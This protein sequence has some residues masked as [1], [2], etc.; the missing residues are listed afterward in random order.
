MSSRF[1]VEKGRLLQFCITSFVF[2]MKKNTFPVTGM[3]CAACASSV[4]SI[5]NNTD[6]V[7]KA[8]VNFASNSVLVSYK[9]AEENLQKALEDIG[10][11]LIL[12][13]FHAEEKQEK[14]RKAHF[15][16]LQRRLLFSSI[17][18]LPIF[19]LGMFFMD[20]TPGKWI[21]MILSIP[22]LF[23]FGKSFFIGAYKQTLRGYANMDTLVA[24]STGVA[25]SF[26][27]FNTL[28]SAYWTSKG[29]I[30]HVYFEA[31]TV[32]ITFIT[33]GK[34][35][36]ERAKY[37]TGSAIKKLMG[38]QPKEVTRINRNNDEERV[39]ISEL[40]VGDL[41]SVKP[42][43]KIPVDGCLVSGH[44]YVDESSIS[45]EPIPVFKKEGDAVTSAG[46]NQNGAFVF[47]AEK[48]GSDT[49]LSRIIQAVKEAQGSKAPIQKTVDKIA[50]VFVPV[51]ITIAVLTF[52]LWYF[53]GNEDVFSHALINAISVLVIAC[54]CAL[55]LATPTALI[56][57][58]GRAAENQ[59]LIKDA[60]SLENAHAIDTVVLDKTGTITE[61]KPRVSQ[62][63]GFETH[64]D[65]LQAV[66]EIEKQSEHPIARAIVEHLEDLNLVP[67]QLNNFKNDPGFGVSADS[68]NG[69]IR[70]GNLAFLDKYKITIT[71]DLLDTVKQ[72]GEQS[73]THVY[74][75]KDNSCIGIFTIVDNIKPTSLE[76][77]N[78]LKKSGIEVAILSGDHPEV[79][80]SMAKRMGI[81][82]YHGGVLPSQKAE[83]VKQWVASGK[84]VAMVGD[85]VNDSEALACAD[86]S[87]AMGKGSDIAM[88]VAH[89]TLISSDLLAIPKAF[90]LS[91]RTVAGIKQN[92]FWAFIYNVIGIPI[93]AGILYP[94]NGFTLDPMIASAAMAMS[95]VSVVGNSLRLKW[96]KIG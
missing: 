73:A 88:D 64:T 63:V 55:G 6:G 38:L 15:I 5:L 94:L 50:A 60:I 43:D 1:R 91:R 76:A 78:Q 49:V 36:E 67:S 84:K 8:I 52:F 95:S 51:V 19:V 28:F 48:V 62:Q 35:L 59:I 40:I 85:G 37:S 16:N 86:V 53:L 68:D 20:W 10:F 11:G 79:V 47:K 4:E 82:T 71:E 22:V 87:I 21:S 80:A 92:L 72:K 41:I 7:E 34:W 93:A 9:I 66:Q 39:P 65:V 90:E 25:F 27:V 61:G 70:I 2:A 75:A 45:G 74:V 46:I 69:T 23:Y 81:E 31:S 17:L 57:G 24:L 30:P 44:S 58:M 96:M 89:M 29:L 3:S 54:P 83:Y 13:E 32:I 77:V 42:G 26:S 18:T 14:N 12:D 56:V 33:F